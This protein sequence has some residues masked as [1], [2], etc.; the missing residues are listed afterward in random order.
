M[1][2]YL[3]SL[4][5]V[6][7]CSSSFA[8]TSEIFALMGKA[9]T[10]TSAKIKRGKTEIPVDLSQADSKSKIKDYDVIV[11]EEGVYSSLG[12]F[13]AK[14]VRVIGQG[15]RKTFISSLPKNSAP[16]FV[17]STEFWD[18]T[19]ADAQFQVS[20]VNGLWAVNV[21]FAGAIL[22]KPAALDKPFG[23][24]I[25]TAFS[26][27]TDSD[28]PAGDQDLYAHFFTKHGDKNRMPIPS[29]LT[30]NSLT[31]ANLL[32]YE[33]QYD[34][35]QNLNLKNRIGYKGL[36]ARG[37][38][39]LYQR[40]ILE[41]KYDQ[42]KFNQLAKQ[43][44]TAKSKGHLY[45]SMLT[46]AEADRL[47]GHSRFDDV[48]KEITP[49]TQNLSQECGCSVE[50]QGLAT[51]IKTEIEQ[52]LFA[53]LPITSLP[54]RCKIQ[55]LHVNTP[56][57]AKKEA[58]ISAAR[59]QVQLDQAASFRA[60]DAA[61][62]ESIVAHSGGSKSALTEDVF[63]VGA[64]PLVSGPQYTVVADVSTPGM[65]KSYTT[66]VVKG[67]NDDSSFIAQNIIDPIAKAFTFQFASK[68]KAATA[69]LTSTDLVA[70]FD[71]LLVYALYGADPTKQSNYEELH[72]QQ[73]GR[74]L[75]T[76]GAMSSVFA[77]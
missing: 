73:F 40:E 8:A 41:P 48:L 12:G 62:Q 21:E 39:Y 14:Y 70:K 7:L 28:L 67:K 72:E 76:T 9:K 23:F 42:A 45:V 6:S 13:N 46:W 27:L 44:K 26:D 19:I 31:V 77:Y 36:F 54:G 24:A 43:A 61:F 64:P 71:G 29:T 25:R 69:K 30:K 50:G 75:S 51:T 16:I 60:Q 68:I 57:G 38:N 11:L 10:A 33:D 18:L 5:L 34:Q 1:R 53:R 32:A 35:I 4:L 55:T 3:I 17:N 74:K 59:L 20:D 37:L 49:L 47:S 15:Q 58:L 2:T 52:K 56:V 65:K 63:E 22:V 66:D